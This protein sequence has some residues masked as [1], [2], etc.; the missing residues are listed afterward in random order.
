MENIEY[1]N[2]KVSTPQDK[3][4]SKNE[5]ERLLKHNSFNIINDEDI[6]N[7]EFKSINDNINQNNRNDIKKEEPQILKEENNK[8]SFTNYVAP[9]EGNDNK[10]NIIKI[11]NKKE[12]ETRIGINTKD[13]LELK[14]ED[15]LDLILFINYSC[16]MTLEDHRYAN[17]NYKIFKIVKSLDKNGYDIIID[18]DEINKLKNQQSIKCSECDCVFE[19]MEYLIEH[20]SS[21]HEKNKNEKEK[22]LK[23]EKIKE[24]SNID[25]KFNKWV[26]DRMKQNE[27]NEDK[28]KIKDENE[29]I[30]DKNEIKEKEKKGNTKEEEM[31]IKKN[32]KYKNKKKPNNENKTEKGSQND[33]NIDDVIKDIL[34]FNDI[35]KKKESKKNEEKEEEKKKKKEDGNLMFTCEVCQKKFISKYALDNHKID[36]NHYAEFA[37]KVC[38]KIFLSE[39]AKENHCKTKNHNENICCTVCEK[40]FA[41]EQAKEYHCKDKSHYEKL[42]CNICKKIFSSK[43]AKEQHCRVKNHYEGFYCKTCDKLFS[44]LEAKEQHCKVKN[45]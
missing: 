6:E 4:N 44:S 13:L 35:P 20:Y 23:N 37:C 34:Q 19:K 11:D 2:E 1:S 21:I 3:I 8:K 10:I 5:D 18:K 9:Y 30:K 26:E 42:Y 25:I 14:K 12:F 45:H 38:N 32:I 40:Y 28:N 7:A 33:D 39:K 31:K 43:E 36:K 15:L 22:K 29:I 24:K 27:I 17:S 16:S 41:S